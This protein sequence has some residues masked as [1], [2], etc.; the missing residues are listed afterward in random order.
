MLNA[1]KM[2]REVWRIFR[3]S[4]NPVEGVIAETAQGRG[5]DRVVDGGTSKVSKIRRHGWRK[6]LPCKLG[7][8]L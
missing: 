3:T 6:D 4:A 7:D 1:I 2:A 8:K 5:S